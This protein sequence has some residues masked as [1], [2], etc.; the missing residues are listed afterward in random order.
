LIL[1][2][3]LAGKAFAMQILGQKKSQVQTPDRLQ[4][5][6][7]TGDRVRADAVVAA[8]FKLTVA[9]GTRWNPAE[10]SAEAW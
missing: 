4:R 8:E 10:S 1:F 6:P 3:Q 9:S 7:Q 2:G 5:E